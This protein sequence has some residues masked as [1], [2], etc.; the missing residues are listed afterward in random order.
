ML[1]FIKPVALTVAAVQWIARF[2]LAKA[3]GMEVLILQCQLFKV[4]LRPEVLDMAAGSLYFSTAVATGESL[5]KQQTVV[6]VPFLRIL[7]RWICGAPFIIC[8]ESPCV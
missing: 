6:K 2:C 5:L 1:R 3:R 4:F 7:Q 8:R